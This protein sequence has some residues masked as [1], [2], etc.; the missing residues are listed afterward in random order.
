MV[1]TAIAFALLATFAGSVSTDE[2]WTLV[3]GQASSYFFVN[4]ADGCLDNA[5]VPRNATA[6]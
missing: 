3:Q 1:L 5:H 6:L 4:A 2:C